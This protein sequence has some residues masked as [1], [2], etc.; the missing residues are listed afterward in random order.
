M[1][2]IIGVQFII[3][4]LPHS[5]WIR[6]VLLLA[7]SLLFPISC[8]VHLWSAL[9]C[10]EQRTSG[11]TTSTHKTKRRVK[12]RTTLRKNIEN[13]AALAVRRRKQSIHNICAIKS[14]WNRLKIIIYLLSKEN[15]WKISKIIIV[16]GGRSLEEVGSTPTT[17]YTE[18]IFYEN[19][20]VIRWEILTPVITFWNFKTFSII[21]IENSSQYFFTNFCKIHKNVS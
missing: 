8:I 4:F 3:S 21:F 6:A 13:E 15:W 19:I 17:I 1:Y 7:N 2:P 16:Y 14:T 9:Y 20:M 11:H 18:R 10:T 12:K 5:Y